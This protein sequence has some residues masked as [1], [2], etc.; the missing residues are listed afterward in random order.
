MSGVI[1]ALMESIVCGDRF[2]TSRS[3][4]SSAAQ[5]HHHQQKQ[6]RRPLGAARVGAAAGRGQPVPNGRP[7]LYA[8]HSVPVATT[9]GT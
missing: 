1:C 5:H 2:V 7:A 8:G 4:T 3:T 6:R 9:G